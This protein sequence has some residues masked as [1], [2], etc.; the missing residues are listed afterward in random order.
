MLSPSSAAPLAAPLRWSYLSALG[1]VCVLLLLPFL[2]KPFNIDDPLFVWAAKQIVAH[3]LDPYGF[4]G[5]WQRHAEPFWS[6][7]Q[8]PPLASYYLAIAGRLFGW[9]EV[10]LHMAMMLIAL[11]AVVGTYLVAARFCRRPGFATL[12]MVCSAAFLVS[13]TTVM[14]DVPLLCLWVWAVYLWLRGSAAESTGVAWAW[15]LG[16]GVAVV[17]A[18]LTKYPGMNLIPL[19]ALHAVVRPPPRRQ[20]WIAQGLALLLPIV[21]LAVY[22]RV[23]AA[24]YGVGLVRDAVGY[25]RMAGATVALAPSIR[26]LNTLSFLGGTLLTAAAVA[27]VGLLRRWGWVAVPVAVVV[28]GWAASRL[29]PPPVSW[30]ARA[31]S[32]STYFGQY[33]LLATAGLILLAA[34]V[35]GVRRGDDRWPGLFLLAWVLGVCVFTFLFNWTVNA[36]SLLPLVPAACILTVRATDIGHRRLSLATGTAVALATALAVAVAFVDDGLARANRFVADRWAAGP[37][38][39]PGVRT[40]RVWFGGHWGFQYYMQLRGASPIDDVSAHYTPGDWVILPAN[41]YGG[42]PLTHLDLIDRVDVDTSWLATMSYTM[43]AGFYFSSGD[44]LPFVVGPMPPE[45]FSI[46]RVRPEPATTHPGTAS[47]DH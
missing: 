32:T 47:T 13:A 42:S 38:P 14:S 29:F 16:A 10:A 17:A 2:A 34:C 15:T 7:M 1:T 23:T 12:L 36:R 28:L 44:R 21:A 39:V 26:A 41:A 3:P 8:N 27:A 37:P 20:T 9:T 4:T 35:I 18:V 11:A 46:G 5:N 40:P 43:G 30:V 24:H 22:D 6:F 25:S 33:G 45:T 31:G 19:L